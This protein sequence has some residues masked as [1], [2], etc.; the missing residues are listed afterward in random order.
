MPLTSTA[1]TLGFGLDLNHSLCRWCWDGWHPS[2]WLGPGQVKLPFRPGCSSAIHTRSSEVIRKV[3][4]EFMTIDFLH[5]ICCMYAAVQVPGGAFRIVVTTVQTHVSGDILRPLCRCYTL[6]RFIW[7]EKNES[8]FQ[9]E[10]YICVTKYLNVCWIRMHLYKMNLSND[11]CLAYFNFTQVGRG[12]SFFILILGCCP[13]HC[14]LWCF[15][16]RPCRLE[17]TS[18]CQFSWTRQ[19]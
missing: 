17:R 19:Q 10:K 13:D 4:L 12:P 11:V 15:L 18:I 8:W 16:C 5:Q 6:L 2:H 7:I 9:S 14:V 1:G 3:H